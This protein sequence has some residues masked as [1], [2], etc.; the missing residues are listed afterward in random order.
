MGLKGL[1]HLYDGLRYSLPPRETF[2]YRDKRIN[3]FREWL[4]QMQAKES[5]APSQEVVD[6]LLLELK[7]DRIVNVD[8]ITPHR[9]KGYLKKL[10]LNK[11]YE[12]TP[13][14]IN[15]LCGLPPPTISP[16]LE[17]KLIN[18]FQEIQTPFESH[19]PLTRKNFLSYSYTL[20]K[21]C[22]LLG[23]YQLIPCFQLLKSREKLYL[24]DTIW[25]GI[26]NDL[27]K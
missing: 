9:I 24:Q 1:A 3:H 17:N 27:L 11:Q 20:H 8:E 5:T 15:R 21:M 25:K 14:L 12:H 7:K 13:A 18:M 16:E 19:C 26:C 10:R 2:G 23:E 22:Q 4:S 6:L